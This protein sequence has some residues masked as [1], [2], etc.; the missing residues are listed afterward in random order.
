M[1]MIVFFLVIGLLFGL[2][3]VAIALAT[4]VLIKR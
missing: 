2:I 3:G 4:L 1:K